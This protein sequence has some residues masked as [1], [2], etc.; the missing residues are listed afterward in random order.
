MSVT[1]PSDIVAGVMR[2]APPQKVKAATLRLAGLAPTAN[3][4]TAP[5]ALDRTKPGAAG[6][7]L[8]MAVL[9]AAEPHRATAAER[10]LASLTA[11]EAG[12]YKSFEAFMLR[13]AFEDMLPPA[14]SGAFGAGFAGGVW[15]S[16][17]AEQF[18]SLYADRGGI[19]L[20]KTLASHRPPTAQPELAREWPYFAATTISS[21]TG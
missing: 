8:I 11:S 6:G 21:F 3:F 12:P 15:R 9:A 14:D 5:G 19:G 20:A 4:T 17:A 16:M 2:A 10:Q 7:D 1:I 13:T 18:A